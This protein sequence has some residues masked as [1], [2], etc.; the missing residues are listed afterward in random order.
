MT[1]AES[2]SA[3]KT[4]EQERPQHPIW[5][6]AALLVGGAGLVA[7]LLVPFMPVL[8]KSTTVTWPE[9]GRAVESTMAF[10][11]PYAPERVHIEV[12]C[13]VLRAGQQRSEPTTLVSSSVPGRATEGFAVSTADDRVLVLVG[14]REIL[15]APVPDGECSTVL[16]ADA[17]GTTVRMAGRTQVEP[18]THVEEVFA[19]AT[20]L[21]PREADGLSVRAT[22][23][24]W[25]SSAPGTSKIVLVGVQLALAATALALLAAADS[26]RRS[27]ALSTASRTA[28]SRSRSGW[29]RRTVDAGVLGVLGFWTV[30]G[31]VT[32]D[33]GFASM[34]AR[35]GV[36]TGVTSNYYR[37]ENTSEAPFALAQ[38]VL[39]PFVAVSGNPMVLRIPSVLAA[40]LTWLVLSR[41]AAP[42]LLPRSRSVGVRT[43]LAVSFL[44]WWLPFGLGTRPEAFTAL[45]GT[46]ALACALSGA[47]R[48]NRSAV[49]GLGALA[50]GLAT[51][52][53]PVGFAGFV[54]FLV[55]APRILRKLRARDPRRPMWS[56]ASTVLLVGCAGSV[57]LIAMF[58]DQ[59]W[60]GAARATE[61]HQFYGPD[62]PWF[63]EALRYENL[64]GFELQGSIARRV[65]VLLTLALLACA[66]LLL[67]RGARHLP[68]MRLIHVAPACLAANVA[69]LWLTP[70]KW[71]HYFGAFAGAGSAAVASSIVLLL[72]VARRWYQDRAAAVIGLITTGMVVLVAATSFS[73]TN[74]WFLYSQFGVLW[75][76]QPLRP[77]NS[78]LTWLLLAAVLMLPALLRTSRSAAN[79]MII[80][81]PA[82]LACAVIA[83]SVAMLLVS[84]A[85]APLRQQDS[86]SPGGQNLARVRGN[87]NCGLMDK[88]V[89]TREVGNGTLE[90]A[91][92]D[93][94]LRGFTPEG[95]YAPDNDPPDPPGTGTARHLWG[96][97]DGGAI[98]TGSMTSRWF[99][100]PATRPDRELA[101]SVAGRTGDGNTLVLEFARSRA[102]D[103]PRPLG[104]RTVDD[105]YED[106]D[107][108]ATY[109]TDHVITQQPQNN[110]N[111]RTLHLDS[112][113]VPPG[114]DR[115]RVRATDATT[116]AGGW[117]AVTGPRVR[118]VLPLREFLRERGRPSPAYVDWS[119]TWSLPCVRDLAAV[120]NGL[121]E[122]PKLLFN[123]PDRLG[124]DGIA[125]YVKG[126]GGS[127]T[128]V[129][130]LGTRT[131]I[132][133]RLLGTESKPRYQD[134][135]RVEIVNY[136]YPT[137]GY[138]TSS[139]WH[140]RWGWVGPPRIEPPLAPTSEHP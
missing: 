1:S 2:G 71:T 63:Q 54:P 33:D 22:T 23:S 107:N 95:G 123:P 46:V 88:L 20:D 102:D 28:R 32:P 121:V 106:S 21:S 31:P 103:P 110:P 133:T 12:P 15:N 60:F 73:G 40:L 132:R 128:G 50:A 134:W 101:V 41:G 43:L 91:G 4:G 14:G 52:A 36:L 139:T 90:P 55:L 104:R 10:F 89:V 39:E 42:A 118:Q 116:D 59:S 25:F 67:A 117:M 78:P 96:S 77:L 8:A 17:G 65:P 18:D 45:G 19:L 137:G 13:R 97:L 120:G 34:I 129:D 44:A 113:D 69:L 7:A 16:D 84:F 100:L 92:G 27:S 79:R 124:F 138:D 61:L 38:Q 87:A 6:W 140:S 130:E 80:R 126:V 94:Q 105:S 81:V 131:E 76:E 49:L 74:N 64:L 56:I 83:S 125:A 98:K 29:L 85:V 68:G 37:W 111:W 3:S 82:V 75:S 62:V 48:P 35:Q 30:L 47:T 109:P 99:D 70:S 9:E 53:S 5:Y 114:A 51:A 57:G 66:A 24:D 119:M 112:R 93:D 11:V 58:F 136:P 108:R 115:V 86:Y 127:F 72:I 26:R 122:P 135:G